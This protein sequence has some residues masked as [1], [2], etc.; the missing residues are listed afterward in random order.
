MWRGWRCYLELQWTL[1]AFQG[2]DHAQS[3]P[4]C[5]CMQGGSFERNEQLL[6][7]ESFRHSCAAQMAAKA[8]RIWEMNMLHGTFQKLR[9][10]ERGS[11]DTTIARKL[12]L[13]ALSS[14]ERHLLLCGHPMH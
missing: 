2:P 7:A 3:Q 9:Q 13:S 4:S 10:A 11:Q 8:V 14:A 6:C 5:L 1:P 12:I